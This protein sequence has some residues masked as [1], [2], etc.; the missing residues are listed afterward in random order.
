M[1]KPKKY[2]YG[3]AVGVLTVGAV[4]TAVLATQITGHQNTPIKHQNFQRMQ[5]Y[6]IF[7][8]GRSYVFND[9]VEAYAFLK[10]KGIIKQKKVMLTSTGLAKY[11][12]ANSFSNLTLNEEDVM[13][14]DEIEKEKG[15]QSLTYVAQGVGG[16]LFQTRVSREDE[17]KFQEIDRKLANAKY[18]DGKESVSDEEMD[19]WRKYKT[20]I[21]NVRNEARLSLLKYT[22]VYEFNGQL[23]KSKQD[24]FSK[25]ISKLKFS[26]DVISNG[27]YGETLLKIIKGEYVLRLIDGE[28]ISISVSEN[29]MSQSGQMNTNN[30]SFAANESNQKTLMNYFIN[31]AKFYLDKYEG[32]KLSSSREVD[33]SLFASEAQPNKNNYI[34]LRDTDYKETFYVA[35]DKSTKNG[36]FYGDAFVKLS[37]SSKLS[38]ISD[39]N[40]WHKSTRE[41][42]PQEQKI[43]SAL[44]DIISSKMD[45]FIYTYAREYA[46]NQKIEMG[47]KSA[48]QFLVESW[49]Q[50]INTSSAN[51][52]I[53][54]VS[55]AFQ[56]IDKTKINTLNKFWTTYTMIVNR[57]IDLN[58]SI[59]NISKVANSYMQLAKFLDKKMLQEQNIFEGKDNDANGINTPNHEKMF[60]ALPFD[61]LSKFDMPINNL[62]PIITTGSQEYSSKKTITNIKNKSTKLFKTVLLKTMIESDLIE[63]IRKNDE[64]MEKSESGETHNQGNSPEYF[65]YLNEINLNIE[66]IVNKKIGNIDLSTINIKKDSPFM[67]QLKTKVENYNKSIS[68]NRGFAS[69]IK[70][71]IQEFQSS[72]D[73]AVIINALRLNSKEHFDPATISKLKDFAGRIK[74]LNLGKEIE[75]IKA[76]IPKKQRG[77]TKKQKDKISALKLRNELYKKANEK[78]SEMHILLKDDTG[79]K[80]QFEKLISSAKKAKTN[81]NNILKSA[82]KMSKELKTKYKGKKTATL[83]VTNAKNLSGLISSTHKLI[84]NLDINKIS[85]LRDGIKELFYFDGNFMD[86][87]SKV[88]EVYQQTL[89]VIQNFKDTVENIKEV[90]EKF[91]TLTESLSKFKKISKLMDK[92][93]KLQKTMKGISKMTKMFSSMSKL[94]T[95]VPVVGEVLMISQMV[96]SIVVDIFGKHDSFAGS[97]SVVYS[98]DAGEGHI[99]YWD[100]GLKT[101]VFWGMFGD[102]E[103][104][105]KSDLHVIKPL[106]VMSSRTESF[107][108][109]GKTYD[110]VG[111]IKHHIMRNVFETTRKNINDQTQVSLEKD[112][113]GEHYLRFHL[114]TAINGIEGDKFTFK[115]KLRKDAFKDWYNEGGKAEKMIQTLQKEHNSISLKD[116]VKQLIE[117]FDEQGFNKV[118]KTGNKKNPTELNYIKANKLMRPARKSFEG[119][120]DSLDGK[121]SDEVVKLISRWI[122]S[123]EAIQHKILV[124]KSSTKDPFKMMQSHNNEG[125]ALIDAKDILNEDAVDTLNRK[126]LEKT[127]DWSLDGFDE[128]VFISRF[129]DSAIFNS[130]QFNNLNNNKGITLKDLRSRMKIIDMYKVQLIK[131]SMSKNGMYRYYSQLGETVRKLTEIYKGKWIEVSKIV[132]KNKIYNK[133]KIYV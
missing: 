87:I 24:I 52:L 2:I 46:Q 14:V 39:S 113:S 117:S 25:I 21:N 123:S 94:G 34:H 110:S 131:N 32:G 129:L 44:S 18:G 12:N 104:V 62:L 112:A 67:K 70:D 122:L 105:S 126:I 17:A 103:V 102:K 74:E 121:S 116:F 48:I 29:V 95:A 77:L 98:Y 132:D 133:E 106:K 130:D 79:L 55:E 45:S 37:D 53:K 43:N 90:V 66:K 26:G 8:R 114:K 15:K 100:G 36:K 51:S 92:F 108:F 127:K 30:F 93:K 6:S 16:Q 118:T 65:A 27:A 124:T 83:F 35:M 99:Y 89:E 61:D 42:L 59:L 97:E 85:E 88:Y 58:E 47:D 63:Q 71:D 64:E 10:E 54:E 60:S 76:N 13:D 69:A 96:V 33:E 72:S 5:N 107:Y 3:G 28:N 75:K 73:V 49:L 9:Q 68:S 7:Y 111:G 81:F 50:E 41:E 120:I 128:Q 56:E 31:S 38:G 82:K 40:N 80:K 19:F 11:K 125:Y 4:T 78:I 109:N 119:K 86:A 84:S 22:D 1:N 91:K 20:K 23:Y 115:V 57:M 101:W